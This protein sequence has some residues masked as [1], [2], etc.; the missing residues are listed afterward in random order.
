MKDSF[1][2]FRAVSAFLCLWMTAAAAALDPS[3]PVQQYVHKSWTS[4]DGLPQNSVLAILQ[5]HDGYL[6]FGTEEGL[7]RF[8][9][10]HFTVFSKDNTPAF[11]SNDISALLEDG[12]DKSIWIGTDRKSVV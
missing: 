2:N 3:K 8:N 11:R 10:N 5:T 12:R 9:G 7:A 1:I 6:W 4:L